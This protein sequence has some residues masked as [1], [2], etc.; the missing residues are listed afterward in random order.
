MH[1]SVTSLFDYA[2]LRVSIR[3]IQ[4]YLP[5]GPGYKSEVQALSEI[6]QNKEVPRETSFDLAEVINFA[7]WQGAVVSSGFRD[8]RRFT[9]AIAIVL[10]HYGNILEGVRP[11]NYLA[12]DLIIDVEE[13]MI[14][15]RQWLQ[16]VRDVFLP[17]RDLLAASDDAD[18]P[19][20]TLGEMILAQLANDYE[21]AASLATQLIEEESRVRNDKGL[22]FAFKRSFLLDL[23][24]FDQFHQDWIKF[25]S[26]LKNPLKDENTQLIIETFADYAARKKENFGREF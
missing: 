4:K 8:F 24:F 25:A 15:D 13:S 3:D 7:G 19:F 2:R 26:R 11:A 12:R 23:T 16:L 1:S 9:S 14:V 10:I 20:F 17:T 5:Q 21:S 18:Y 22:I 6:L